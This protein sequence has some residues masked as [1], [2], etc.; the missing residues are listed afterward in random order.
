MKLSHALGFGLTFV[1]EHANHL[2]KMI[3]LCQ[4]KLFFLSFSFLSLSLLLTGAARDGVASGDSCEEMIYLYQT[5][6]FSLFLSLSL[7]VAYGSCERRRCFG[8]FLRRDDLSL[9]NHFFFPFS[10]SLFVA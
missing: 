5:T 9:P 8:R 1:I 4:T 6:F 3:Y 2:H 10:F 7:I